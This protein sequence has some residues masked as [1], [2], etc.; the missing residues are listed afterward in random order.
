M[1]VNCAGEG[2][3]VELGGSD[4]WLFCLVAVCQVDLIAELIW[5]SMCGCGL[6]AGL[7][8]DCELGW[9]FG[10]VQDLSYGR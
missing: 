6:G 8:S 3:V 2:V 9:T 4:V 7:L 1:C 5:S 10:C